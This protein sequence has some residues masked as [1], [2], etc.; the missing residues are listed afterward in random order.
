MLRVPESLDV[1]CEGKPGRP[2]HERFEVA[3]FNY[4]PPLADGS[5]RAESWEYYWDHT[6]SKRDAAGKLKPVRKHHKRPDSIETVSGFP[7]DRKWPLKCGFCPLAEAP[8]PEKI[9]PILDM[10]YEAFGNQV[11]LW[12]VLDALRRQR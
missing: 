6:S 7:Q 10:L 12:V 4:R 1:V 3:H 11:P 9:R 8:R 5:G 2:P